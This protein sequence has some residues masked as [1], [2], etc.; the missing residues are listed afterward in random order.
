MYTC[1]CSLFLQ[2]EYEEDFI[3][4]QPRLPEYCVRLQRWR[5]KYEKYLDS[6]PRVQTL[7]TVSHYLIDY[8]HSKYDDIEIPGQYTEVSASDLIIYS[9][10]T[11]H[12]YI[13]QGR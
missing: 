11:D 7:D 1:G 5:D 9:N 12:T 4:S 6:R 13:G 3:K 10:S 8:P 2:K